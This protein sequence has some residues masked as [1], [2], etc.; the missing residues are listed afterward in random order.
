MRQL[1]IAIAL[2]LYYE[3]LTLSNKDI[4]SIFGIT[5]DSTATKI[6]NEVVSYFAESEKNPISALNGRIKT[7][8]AFEAW[9]VDIKNL[10]LRFR[11]LQK[12]K[13]APGNCVPKTAK[14]N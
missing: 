11:K 5:S 12:I 7:E 8:C 10:E 9:G 3:R 14:E 13:A 2:E 6:K 4:K 1:N